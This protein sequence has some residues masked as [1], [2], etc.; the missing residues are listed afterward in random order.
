MNS[1]GGA[2]TGGLR[3]IN[4]FDEEVEMYTRNVRIKLRANSVPE[5]RRILEQKI[6]PLLRTQRGFQDEITLLTSQR[7]EAIA[8]SFWDNQENA[9][10]Y[11]HVAYLDVLRALSN[12][13]ESLPIVETFELVDSTFH[14]N[15][16]NAA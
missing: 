7:N 8:I 9:D 2:E 4:R 3:R 11:N 5:F 6:V 16:A 1:R 10:A 15:T 14:E 13:I 12:V